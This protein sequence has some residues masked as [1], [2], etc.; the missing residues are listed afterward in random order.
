M[1]WAY[2]PSQL[3]R[4]ELQQLPK[5]LGQGS[6][7]LLSSIL[8]NLSI[9]TGLSLSLYPSLSPDFKC[10]PVHLGVHD[11]PFLEGHLSHFQ[12]CP[13][14]YQCAMTQFRLLG[15]RIWPA[16]PGPG[17]HI[18]ASQWWWER[19]DILWIGLP[20]LPL[21]VCVC[22]A[23]GWDMGNFQKRK[24]GQEIFLKYLLSRIMRALPT[25]LLNFS[26][27]KPLHYACERLLQISLPFEV[28]KNKH[29]FL[30]GCQIKCRTP[31]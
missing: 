5:G 29:I 9:I 26:S 27:T 6:R 7:Q 11:S 4:Q 25:F 15:E 1:Y 31:S 28:W 17:V 30:I 24:V 10:S 20:G 12:W 23:G 3:H 22:V 21:C 13:L 8:W 14:T 2:P 16:Q 18:R 19:G